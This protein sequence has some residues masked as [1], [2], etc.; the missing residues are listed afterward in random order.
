M[1]FL[2]RCRPRCRKCDIPCVAP[3]T[4]R[5]RQNSNSHRAPSCTLVFKTVLINLLRIVILWNSLHL[6]APLRN[7]GQCLHFQLFGVTEEK[8]TAAVHVPFC[9]R[10]EISFGE[11]KSLASLSFGKAGCHLHLLARGYGLY[12]MSNIQLYLVKLSGSAVPSAS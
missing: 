8:H 6:P 12:L 10:N 7:L 11:T 4:T 1:Q 5:C 9:W 3:S 2:P